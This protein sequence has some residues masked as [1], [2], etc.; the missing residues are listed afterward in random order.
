M[1]ILN[2]YT[3][4][5]D[6]DPHFIAAQL[7]SLDCEAVLLDFQRPGSE[8]AAAL[9]EHLTQSL[10]C[11]VGVSEAYA[12]NLSCPV[13]LPPL[14]PSEGLADYL[15]PWRGREVWLELA[16]SREALVLTQEGCQAVPMEEIP[17]GGFCEDALHCHYRSFLE[18]DAARFSLWRTGEDLKGLLAQ[19][20][21]LGVT[22]AIGLWQEL[23]GLGIDN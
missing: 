12:G 1:V 6:H 15:S 20:Q 16:L 18:P 22:K 19:A 2:D 5:R 11:P 17:A 10:S 14:R 3:P 4:I 23:G 9:A 8:E 21:S 13:F 7:E